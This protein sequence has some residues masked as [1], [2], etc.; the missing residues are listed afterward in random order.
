M[1]Q[2]TVNKDVRTIGLDLGDTKSTYC[3][4]DTEGRIV[5]E[6]SIVTSRTSPRTTSATTWSSTRWGRAR[7]AAAGG[8]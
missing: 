1:T 8:C 3:V 7:S 6:S 2:N 5:S 4:M